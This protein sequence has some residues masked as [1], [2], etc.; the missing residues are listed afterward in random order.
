MRRCTV[1]A[2]L[3]LALA[4]ALAPGRAL[5]ADKPFRVGV[6]SL[7]NPRSAPQFVALEERLRQL[8][9][10][11]GRELVIDFMVLDGDADRYPAAMRELV[12]RQP[13]VLIAPGPEVSLKAARAATQTIPI[14]MIAVDYDAVARGY[15]QSLARPG[16]NIT[17]VYLDTVD[18]AAK[19][20]EILK[21]TAPGTS[22]FIVLWDASGAD[23]FKLTVP[24]AEALGVQLRPVEF[25]DAPYD[26]EKALAS[27]SPTAGDALLCMLS[28]YFFHDR[29]QLDA[30]ALRHKLPSMCGGV[31]S[32]GLVAYSASLNALFAKTAE[33]V[34]KIRQGAKP[35]DLP[36]EGPTRFKLVL[37][38]RFAKA[39]GLTIPPAIL[40][41]ADEVIE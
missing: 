32:G 22:R 27:A 34:D 35:G 20:V 1:L 39:L 13:D 9:S 37:D 14:V 15:V 8:L 38:L 19:R 25:R 33:Y 18:V 11:A 26:Y 23:S 30:L 41:R 5:A 3:G 36:I 10:A 12:S 21:E 2:V 4:G 40:A 16:G 31:D 17:G 29:Q 6:A 7:V 28:P 24:A